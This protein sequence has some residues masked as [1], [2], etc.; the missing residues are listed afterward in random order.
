[1]RSSPILSIMPAASRAS[2]RSCLTL[3]IANTIPRSCQFGAQLVEHVECGEVDLHVRLGVE[4]EPLDGVRVLVD[5]SQRP[6]AEVLGVCEEQRRVVAIHHQTRHRVG[7][8]VVVEIMHARDSGDESLYRVVRSGH[9]AQQVEDRQHDGHQHAVEHTEQQYRRRGGQGE[10]QLAASKSGQPLELRHIDQPQRGIH[11]QC[12]Q[13]GHRKVRQ[14]AAPGHHHQKHEHQRDHRIELRAAAE[15]V[16]ER[17]ATAAGAHRKSM[18]QTGSDVADAQRPQ[19]RV[20]V[21]S[22]AMAGRERAGGQHVVGERDDRDACGRD[23]QRRKI[24]KRDTGQPG[25]RQPA[26][27]LPDHPNPVAVQREYRQRPPSPAASR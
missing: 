1:M 12:P 5:G 20:C 17:G 10:E 2:R 8:R 25:C 14:H 11:H 13:R 22:L 3:A 27:D 9:P 7:G 24:R 18:Q 15:C 4:H 26:R 21:H 6:L 16:A 19:L 23:Q